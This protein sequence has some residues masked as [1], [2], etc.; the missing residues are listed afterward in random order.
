MRR[1][2]V[3]TSLSVLLAAGATSAAGAV[4]PHLAPPSACPDQEAAGVSP[5]RQRAAM[6]CMVR[7]ARRIEGVRRLRTSRVLMR[8]AQG[9]A[10]LIV[11]CGVLTHAPCGQP[12]DRVLARAG[13][14]GASFENIAS[15]AGRF[16]TAR[17]TMI[18]WL[19]S[20]GHRD[21]LL[22]PEVSVVGVGVR[23]RVGTRGWAGGTVWALHLGRPA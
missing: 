14:R 7:W 18:M 16:G 21:A 23:P 12:W 22:R 10:N 1:P 15:G 17:G 5:A 8:A 6:L 20:A 4:D 3:T 2:L 11:R 19:R 9:K 13:F